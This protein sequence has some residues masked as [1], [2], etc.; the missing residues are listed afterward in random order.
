[1]NISQILSS[2]LLVLLASTSANAAE[3]I[4]AKES[5]AT[6]AANEEQVREGKIINLQLDEL[7][8]QGG[9]YAYL[10]LSQKNRMSPFAVGV[11][12]NGAVIILEVP[13]RETKATLTDKVLKLR[14][15]LKLA[16]D[17]GK[18]VAG[19]LFV[20][21]KVPH[22]GIQVDGVAIELEHIK[23]L[24]IVRFSPYDLDFKS[25]KIKF[26]TPVE[27]IKPVVFFKDAK[28]KFNKA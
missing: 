14:E 27:K 10:Q 20:Q 28:K 26:R 13:K 1:M 24:S 19:A 11:E 7:T 25:Q 8:K 22:Q 9:K 5:K 18:F 17:G 6:A 12:A 16:A 15:M 23:G 4:P 2:V 21:A 3:T